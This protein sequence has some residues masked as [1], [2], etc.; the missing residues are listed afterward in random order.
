MVAVEVIVS[1]HVVVRVEFLEPLLALVSPT[2]SVLA[3]AQRFI[4]YY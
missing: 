4:Y 1:L 3:L 2:R